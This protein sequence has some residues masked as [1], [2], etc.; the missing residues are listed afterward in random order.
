MIDAWN[1]T[2]S[3]RVFYI[4]L[5]Y[6]ISIQFDYYITIIQFKCILK[7]DYIPRHSFDHV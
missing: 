4:N 5:K 7:V 1:P 6:Y 3:A 2:T